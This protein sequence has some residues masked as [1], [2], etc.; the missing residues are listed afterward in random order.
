MTPKAEIRAFNFELR[1]DQSEQ[2]GHFI[3]GRPIVFNS[4]TDLGWYD[5]I[6]EAG[7]L[8][9]T[10]LKDVRFLVNHN[11]DMIPLARSRNNN[12]N[13]TMQ[14]GVNEFGMDIRAT[15]DVE[16]SPLAQSYYSAI[17][18]G[19]IDKMSFMFVVGR[20]EWTDIDTDHPTRIIR[21]IRR[22]F[23]VS[24]VTFPAYEQTFIQTSRSL[25][26]ALDS[27]RSALESV[28][29]AKRIENEMRAKKL[30]LIKIYTEV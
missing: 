8:D 18:R 27:A 16:A 23:E 21:E 24:A 5:E 9:H 26:E 17:N 25:V 2:H 1:A 20:D 3:T 6:I 28:R 11:T 10:D 19:D 13:S 22:V 30:K 7:A 14:L 29:A 4:R 12:E 15:L